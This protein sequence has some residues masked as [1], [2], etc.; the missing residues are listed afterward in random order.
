MWCGDSVRDSARR[1]SIARRGRVAVGGSRRGGEIG[2]VLRVTGD[3]ER[4]GGPGIAGDEVR[5][6]V[7]RALHKVDVLAQHRHEGLDAAVEEVEGRVDRAVAEDD[8]KV[9]RPDRRRVLAE[10][11]DVG[12]RDR[13]NRVAPGVRGRRGCLHGSLR[14]ML[15]IPA[16]P[17]VKYFG[18][19]G[20]RASG[21]G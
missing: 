12:D 5:L 4:R 2:R 14:A 11:L 17:D 19:L 9:V 10:G 1:R 8:D 20:A 16:L 13:A 21:A 3:G 7:A 15:G 18:Y 6:A